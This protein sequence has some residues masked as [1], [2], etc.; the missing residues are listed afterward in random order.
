[1]LGGQ[2]APS[3]SAAT[4]AGD[5]AEASEAVSAIAETPTSEGQPPELDD[6]AESAFRAEARDR[7]ETVQPAAKSAPADEEAERKPL[8]PLQDLV[9]RIPPEIR[10]TLDELFRAKFITVKRVPR[11][12]LKS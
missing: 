8:P 10:E 7:G 3:V 6:V 12:A 1:M 4:A 5:A 11:N 9:K 2:P